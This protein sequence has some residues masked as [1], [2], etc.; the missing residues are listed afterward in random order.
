MAGNRSGLVQARPRRTRTV[1]R[2]RAWRRHHRQSAADSLAR[3]LHQPL[4]S[5]LTWL[6]IGVAL[7]LPSGLW[8]TL[9]NLAR[10]GGAIDSPATLSLF[11]ED[12]TGVSAGEELAVR[13]GARADVQGVRF[14]PRDEALADFVDQSGM[15]DLLSGLPD[16]P[17]PH[18]LVVEAANGNEATIS[19]LEGEFR[20]LPAV[21]EVVVD[22]LWLRRL[23]AIMGL[24]RR[25]IGFL[26]ALLIG[27]V[28]LVVGNTIRLTIEGRRDE[29]VIS[30]LVGG[31]N[32]FVRRPILYTGLWYGFGG[33]IC[34]AL[35]VALGI[36]A[37]RTPVAALAATYESRFE[38]IGLGLVDSLQLALVGAFL[39]L[40][41]A[42]LAAA[43][44][45]RDIEPE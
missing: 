25:A 35:L 6:V 28:V 14:V 29:V 16:N 22:A 39:G 19:V 1:D 36:L 3:V 9:D 2:W 7:A 17:L 45:L 24:A 34:A 41:G 30:K 26:G 12:G 40:L 10:V 23:Q 38:L 13:I 20:G 42:W 21:E 11:L 31:S 33:G 8:I 43:R 15:G 5:L 37:L 27:A 18:L 44:H 32:A 4:A